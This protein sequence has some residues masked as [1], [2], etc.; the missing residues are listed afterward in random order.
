M[1]GN[2]VID[3]ADP[4]AWPDACHPR[5]DARVFTAAER[6]TIAASPAPARAR[7]IY[8]AAKESAYKAARRQDAATV[9]APR[10]FVV[11]LS[12]SAEARLG[13]ADVPRAS[14]GSGAVRHDGDRFALRVVLGPDAVHA[15]AWDP[16]AT[17]LLLADVARLG[18]VE[19][20]PARLSAAARALAIGAIARALGVAASRLAVV[21]T[22]GAPPRLLRDGG[23]SDTTLSLSHH[24]RLVAF[25][26]LLP[27]A[28]GTS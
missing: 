14:G 4:E 26:C 17:G 8:W 15:I 25:A 19:P 1:V 9:F 22:A 23:S 12:G 7:W 5:F 27:D 28:V 21:R 3:L 6:A 13:H 24:G 10:R 16:A 20:T 2:D 11:R 18:G